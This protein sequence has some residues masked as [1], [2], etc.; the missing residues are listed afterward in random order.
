MKHLLLSLFFLAGLVFSS[1]NNESQSNDNANTNKESI[2]ETSKKS[3]GFNSPCK[4]FTLDDVF[5]FFSISDTIEITVK[6][7]VLT[8][9][10]CSYKWKTGE[11]IESVN[12][13]QSSISYEAESELMI[14][15]VK[16]AKKSMYDAAVKSYGEEIQDAGLGQESVWSETRSQVSF[17][18]NSYM[19]HV[20]V[21]AFSSNEQNKSKAIEVSKK[22]ISKLD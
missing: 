15:M 5:S 7:K 8:Y 10:T 4:I 6:D 17:L 3:E 11:Y 13:G 9:P 2:A 22:I 18:Y 12:V 21:K 19:F 20:Y 16:D 1:C 14:V